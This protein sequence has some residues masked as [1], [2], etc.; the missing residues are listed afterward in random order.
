MRATTASCAGCVQR[1]MGQ[2]TPF[3]GSGSRNAAE[4]DPRPNILQMNTEGLTENKIS[5]IEQLTYK[6]K[7]FI[8]V[9]QETHCT[10]AEKLVIPNFSLAKSVLSRN[11]GL[12]TF[13]HERLEW[14]PVVVVRRRRKIQDRQRLQTSTLAT[15]P[16]Q[17]PDVPTPQ[18]VRWRLQLPACQLGLQHPR[19][20]RAWTPGQHPTTLD[21]CTTQR[22]QPV[23]SLAVGTSATTQTWPSRVSARTADRGQT[24][25]RK[26]PEVTTS[27]LP[28]NATKIPGSCPQRSGEALELSQGRL[29]ALLLSHR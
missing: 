21:C 25:P 24:R 13:V 4:D 26:V 28:H 17:H 2:T 23:S 6:N 8:I 29:E 27:A 22:K 15:R 3:S 9:L 18:S 19:T 1:G 14:S 16:N 11:H 7:A 12:A 20:V 5:V 10:T